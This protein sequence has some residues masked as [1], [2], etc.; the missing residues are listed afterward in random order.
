LP[1]P[2]FAAPDSSAINPASAIMPKPEEVF[3]S[4]SRRDIEN[5][6]LGIIEYK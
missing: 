5:A 2:D 1:R 3:R 4:M 6:E